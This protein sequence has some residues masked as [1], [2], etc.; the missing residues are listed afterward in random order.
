MSSVRP[1]WWLVTGLTFLWL[2]S[3]RPAYAY[4]DPGTGSYVLQMLIAVLLAALFALKQYW[5]RIKD[6]FRNKLSHDKDE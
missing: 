2:M 5:A 1:D 3:S 6:F 4:I